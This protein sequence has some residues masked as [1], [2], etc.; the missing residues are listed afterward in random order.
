M[1]SL[2]YT[3]LLFLLTIDKANLTQHFQQ[4]PTLCETLNVFDIH[5][6]FQL[7]KIPSIN[8]TMNA[9]VIT[10]CSN[11]VATFIWQRK[12]IKIPKTYTSMTD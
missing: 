4:V 12:K 7:T 3:I 10:V 6:P 11:T 1:N 2:K 8:P 5:N 9:T